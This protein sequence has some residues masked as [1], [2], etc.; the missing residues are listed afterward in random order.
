MARALSAAGA[1]SCQLY[2][3]DFTF[4]SFDPAVERIADIEVTRWR[5]PDFWKRHLHPHDRPILD[6]TIA[7]ALAGRADTIR[8]V[9]IATLDGA[10]VSLRLCLRHAVESV[11]SPR[12]LLEGYIVPD[13]TVATAPVTDTVGA[14]PPA[15]ELD[16]SIASDARELREARQDL[17]RAARL[18]TAGE[19]LG[20]ITHDLR[21]PLTALQMDI[22]IATHL[23]RGTPPS[24]DKALAALDDAAADVNRVRESLQVIQDLVARREPS[25]KPVGLDALVE[26]V[27]RLVLSEAAARRVRLDIQRAPNL[28]A[29]P[30]DRAMIREAL[31]SVVLAAIENAASREGAAT[32]KIV[33]GM[34][35]RQQVEVTLSYRPVRTTTDDHGWALSVARSVAEAHGGTVT[36]DVVAGAETTVRS[37]WPISPGV[38]ET[39]PGEP[40]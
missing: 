32:V 5:A 7:A 35:D 38:A 27:V 39:R 16:S 2:A 31:L 36:V 18:A 11:R 19:L 28:P 9:R 30:G 29:I 13:P 33:T 3:D 15:P 40:S 22:G 26:E 8:S 10:Y 37:T 23:L 6:E 21:Q 34:S 20:G 4:R 1:V 17:M 25:R 14:R 24:V 12:P